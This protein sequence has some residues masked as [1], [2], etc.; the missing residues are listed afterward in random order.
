MTLWWWIG[1]FAQPVITIIT[2]FI[3]W[4]YTVETKRL[5][6]T[7]ERQIE[8]TQKQTETLQRPFVVIEP[9]WQKGSLIRFTVRNVGNSAAVN[10]E[11]VDGQYRLM[12]P[13]LDSKESVFVG[14]VEDKGILRDIRDTMEFPE[15]WQEFTL[16]AKS[17]SKGTI[18]KI[19]YCNVAM[20][21]Y[22]T[23]QQI[24]PGK[25]II[26]LSGEMGLYNALS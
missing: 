20:V 8:T 24:F 5:R 14:V 13:I 10:V 9:K 21:Q 19:E 16:D 18:I 23:T 17:I 7:A 15:G 12:I 11:L 6:K 4:W 25:V 3:V 26:E 1:Y 22:H 2:A